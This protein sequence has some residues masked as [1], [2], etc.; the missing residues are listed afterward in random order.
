MKK[1]LFSPIDFHGMPLKNAL[2]R[3][4]TNE[5]MAQENH[6][7]SNK[8]ILYY[9]EM[10]K[11]VGMIITGFC[12][13][14][15]KEIVTK[16]MLG[17]DNDAHIEQYSYLCQQVHQ[18][19]TKIL[20]Q[21]VAGGNYKSR[22]PKDYSLKEIQAIPNIF[23]TCAQRAQRAGF[24]GVQLHFAHGYILSQFLTTSKN[25]RT[26]EYGGSYGNR[27]RIHKEIIQEIRDRC[28]KDF[29]ISIKIHCDDFMEQGFTLEECI[30][31]SQELEQLGLNSIEISGGNYRSLSSDG[32]YI[33]EADYI[34]QRVN[35]PVFTVGGNKNI[36]K[37]QTQFMNTNVQAL[38]MSRSLTNDMCFVDSPASVSS[39]NKCGSC[40][41]LGTPCVQNLHKRTLFAT[42]FD[43]TLSKDHHTITSK[44]IA[45]IK[46]YALNNVFGIVTG[47]D[48]I[49]LLTSLN[50]VHLPYDFLVCFNG[51]LCID[52]H[53]DI[54]HNEPILDDLQALLYFFKKSDAISCHVIGYQRVLLHYNCEV[55]ESMKFEKELYKN[56]SIVSSL[57]ELDNVYMLSCE[58]ANEDVAK[59][60][61]EHINV[62]FPHLGAS[63][64][65]NFIDIMKVG[66]SKLKG[67]QIMQSHYKIKD[68]DMYVVGDSYNDIKMI[69]Y[70]QGFAM[71]GNKEVE[72]ISNQ[73]VD[74][75]HEAIALSMQKGS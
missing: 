72:A 31:L 19:H 7:P 14:D 55:D 68:K 35:I 11:H 17:L 3:S 6:S 33:K 71:R 26:D 38:S 61:A 54:L 74:H 49:S 52:L 57:E 1:D 73:V 65:T 41:T 47:R 8:L 39:C 9:E 13:P 32:F 24:D 66:I 58:F 16:H 44:D 28:R 21:I 4:A 46:E 48:P 64:N 63:A 22:E 56:H 37:M 30:M 75:V 12:Y 10:A 69:E 59:K 15:K 42:D 18:H 36:A 43:G 29:H 20:L 27:V 51:A 53:G 40:Y 45:S 60:Y 70:Y 62:H 23:A 5:N 50:Q 34:A 2:I 25:T 67:M